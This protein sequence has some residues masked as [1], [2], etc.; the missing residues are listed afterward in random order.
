M[1]IKDKEI[2]WKQVIVQHIKWPQCWISK[3]QPY[4]GYPNPR[5]MS[6]FHID[7]L[8]DIKLD[9]GYANPSQILLVQALNIL[10]DTQLS[11]WISKFQP[12]I[13]PNPS[14]IVLVQALNILSDTQLRYWISNSIPEYPVRYSAEPLNIQ[15]PARY[16]AKYLSLYWISKFQLDVQLD[17]QPNIGYPARNSIRY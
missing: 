16:Q 7:I 13:K 2:T 10:P 6:K 17:I 1:E 15:V 8:P 11:Y 12:D 4:I 3:L 14:H 5:W 9:I